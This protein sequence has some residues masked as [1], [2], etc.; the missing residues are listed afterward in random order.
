MDETINYNAI[1]LFSEG[2]ELYD[3]GNKDDA[4]KKIKTALEI[5]PNFQR[6]KDMIDKLTNI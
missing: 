3:S 2:L 1:L 6:A 4:L 5:E